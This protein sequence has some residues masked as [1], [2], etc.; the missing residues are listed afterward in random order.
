MLDDVNSLKPTIQ[1]Q[2]IKDEGNEHYTE[3]IIEHTD[4]ILDQY[5]N[6]LFELDKPTEAEI[7]KCVKN[8]VLE[9]NELDEKYGFIETVE[10]EELCDFIY[11]SA[12]KVGL[13]SDEDITEQWREW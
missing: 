11:L 10:R 8:V 6:Q 4:M 2:Q 7:M 5:I 9:L 12:Q 3:D 1:W 13:D